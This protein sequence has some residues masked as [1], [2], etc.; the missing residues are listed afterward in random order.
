M[1]ERERVIVDED[2]RVLEERRYPDRERRGSMSRI[3]LILLVIV[4]LVV[5]G[6]FLLGG[7]VDID[8]EG[9][10]EVPEVDVD[11]NNPDVDVDSEEAP[12]ASAEAG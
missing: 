3:L 9:D 10:V 6:W 5:V 2:G 4:A 1:A 12:P 11:V 7:S 8:T